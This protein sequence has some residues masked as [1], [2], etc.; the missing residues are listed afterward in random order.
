MGDSSNTVE[1]DHDEIMVDGT[2]DSK[3]LCSE[4]P[5][6]DK[7]FKTNKPEAT[8][9]ENV[10]KETKVPEIKARVTG[11]RASLRIRSKKIAKDAADVVMQ[12]EKLKNEDKG[13]P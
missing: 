3:K 10:E 1:A 5:K 2:T 12:E 9:R 11:S 4:K 6:E 7:K 8:T 13:I